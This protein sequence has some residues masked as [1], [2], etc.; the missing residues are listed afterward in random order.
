MTPSEF[1]AEAAWQ[2]P[3]KTAFATAKKPMAAQ[4]QPLATLTLPPQPRTIHVNLSRAQDAPPLSLA[5]MTLHPRLTT[6]RVL[7]L[8]LA[9]NVVETASRLEIAIVLETKKMLWAF[10][11]EAALPTTTTMASVTM[12]MIVL[13]NSTSVA[14]ATE[15]APFQDL[16][17]MAT[18][19]AISVTRH[20]WHW[21]CHS[22]IRCWIAK[23]IWTRS[24]ANPA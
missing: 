20:A 22:K 8:M 17:A 3:T 1:V 7:R 4:I 5:T 10:A 18:H 9:A 6:D 24:A 14:F 23:K 13:E 19:R 2:T 15:T 11:E 16:T 21:M 12:Q